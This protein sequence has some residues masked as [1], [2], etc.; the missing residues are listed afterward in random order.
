VELSRRAAADGDRPFLLSLFTE[1]RAAEFA[2]LALEGAALE[3]LLSMQFEAQ[4]QAYRG[5]HPRGEFEL[6]MIDGRP[7]GRLSVDRAGSA[8]ELLDIALTSGYRGYG[9]GTRL[10]RE[11]QDEARVAGLPLRLHVARGNP[12]ARLYERLGFA[13]VAGDDVYTQM[14]WRPEAGSP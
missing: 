9:V 11:L 1:A 8:I 5:Q 6:V 13:V 12:A 4:E 2:A 3:A 7:A 10:V 14:E